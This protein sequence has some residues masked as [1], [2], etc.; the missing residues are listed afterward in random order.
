MASV[1]SLCQELDHIKKWVGVQ[2]SGG[3]DEESVTRHQLKSIAIRVAKLPTINVD[4]AT[5]LC[6]KIKDIA[7]DS[8]T[9]D[10][11]AE[12]TSAVCVTRRPM[13]HLN[14]SRLVSTSS[15]T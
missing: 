6:E 15:T 4:D 12:L 13:R 10:D 3:M 8:W 2:V 1:A 9:R 14:N 5:T 7:L 11:L